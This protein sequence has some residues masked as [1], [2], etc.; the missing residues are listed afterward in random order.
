MTSKIKAKPHK[1]MKEI[2][3]I[4]TD[5]AVAVELVEAS[6]TSQKTPLSLNQSSSQKLCLNA[7]KSQY[8]TKKKRR[9]KPLPALVLMV[10]LTQFPTRSSR[11]KMSQKIS[12]VYAKLMLTLSAQTP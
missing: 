3:S 6:S 11:R 4:T 2:I 12:E 5:A 7:K 10:S 8:L 1:E 9:A